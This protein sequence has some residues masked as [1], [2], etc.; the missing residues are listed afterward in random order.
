[1]SEN[2]VQPTEIDYYI[3]SIRKYQVEDVGGNHWLDTHEIILKLNQQAHLEASSHQEELVKELL[4]ENGKLPILVHELFCAFVWRLKILPK[5]LEID[6]NPDA[7][8]MMYTVFYHEATIVSMIEIVLYHENGCDALGESALDLIDYCVQGITHLIG[9]VSLGHFTD[10][11]T[12][13]L[14]ETS[15]EEFE[16]QKRDIFYK[17]G[18]RCLTILSYLTDKIDKLPLSAVGRLVQ[19]HDVPCLLSEILHSKPW[20]RH[21]RGVDKY[22]DDEWKPVSGAGLHKVTKN[23]AQAW[24]CFRQ[25]LFNPNI[26]KCYK[27]NEF[28]Q[29][30]LAKCQDLLTEQLLDQLPPLAE[31]KHYL[32]TLQLNGSQKDRSKGI[33][34]E[35]IPQIKEN[36][37]QAAILIGYRNIAQ[38]QASIFLNKCQDEIVEMAKRLNIAYNMEY[39]ENLENRDRE[40]INS[41][42][43]GHCGKSA[44]KKCFK[45]K[46]IYYCCRDC[47]VNDWPNHKL[48][49]QLND[50]K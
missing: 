40:E 13:N 39:L 31:L 42:L 6:S 21:I 50:V 9:L 19:T 2:I 14:I 44:D 1:M 17:I 24:F 35:E 20:I 46:L 41:H 37:M 28:R 8:F 33:L 23:E 47:Q 48:Q 3:L 15:M 4:V 38:K 29:R 30:S 5:L 11:S 22:I 25:L 16:R 26:I 49:C 18:M 36:I 12:Q 10:V 34:L 7:T 32:C 43:C 45:C 27:I